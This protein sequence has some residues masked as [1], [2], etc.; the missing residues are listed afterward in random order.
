MRSLQF[1]QINPEFVL[2]LARYLQLYN[3]GDPQYA[4][5]VL[6][7]ILLVLILHLI[8]NGSQKLCEIVLG[9]LVDHTILLAPFLGDGRS[10]QIARS[11]PATVKTILSSIDLEPRVRRYVQCPSCYALYPVEKPYPDLCSHRPAPGSLPCQAKMTR[12]KTVHGR[13]HRQPIRI[14]AHQG[15]F[16]FAL[17]QCSAADGGR[18]SIP[19]A[20]TIHLQ[21]RGGGDV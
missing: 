9:F 4:P 11:Y 1:C 18:R 20:W 14:Y 21:K 17:R 15:K 5:I 10:Q 6:S 3:Y 7:G 19:L 2:F 12:I 16:C 8:F 13:E